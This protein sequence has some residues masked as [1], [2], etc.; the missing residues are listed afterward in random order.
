MAEKLERIVRA[1]NR[2]AFDDADATLEGFWDC[3][4]RLFEGAAGSAP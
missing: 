1:S 2:M 4:V 3:T